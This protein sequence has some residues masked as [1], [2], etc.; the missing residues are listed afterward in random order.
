MYIAV[1][2][3]RG[4]LGFGSTRLRLYSSLPNNALDLRPYQK[5]CIEQCLKALDRGLNKVVVSLATGGGKTVI[6]SHLIDQIKPNSKTGGRKTLVLVHRQELADQAVQKIATINQLYKVEKDQAKSKAS[7]KDDVD[8]VVASVP[9]LLRTPDRLAKY[10]ADDYKAIIVDE[11][12]HA[13]TN[14]FMRVL[15][16]F[17]VSKRTDTSSIALIGFSATLKRRDKIPL[18]RVFDEV[19]FDMGLEEMI[20]NGHLSDFVWSRVATSL[21]LDEVEIVNGDYSLGGLSKHVNKPEVNRMVLRLYLRMRDL[22]KFKSSLFFCVNVQHVQD[23]CDLFNQN[24]IRAEYVTGSTPPQERAEILSAFKS[25]NLPVLVNCGVFTEGTDIPNID[26]LFLVRPTKSQPLLTQM[27]GR[28]LRLNEG[29]QNCHIF[30]FVDSTGISIAAKAEIDGPESQLGPSIMDIQ[31]GLNQTSADP[32]ELDIE[33]IEVITYEGVEK[34][35]NSE[36]QQDDGVPD[37]VKMKKAKYPWVRLKFESWGLKISQNSHLRIDKE[38][39]HNYRLVFVDLRS[40]Q[41]STKSESPDSLQY[42]LAVAMKQTSRSIKY[43]QTNVIKEILPNLEA[44]FEEVESFLDKNTRYKPVLSLLSG[45]ITE[46]QK[47]FLRR[48][49]GSIASKSL[50]RADHTDFEV[51]LDRVLNDLSKSDA[52]NLIFAYSVS[53]KVALQIFM[54][55]EVLKKLKK[56][57]GL[58]D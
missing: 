23:I 29:K 38:G 33:K 49:C 45:N 36:F 28:G 32:R 16:Y 24:G 26:S 3:W 47:A 44:A 39:E 53:G 25:G 1:R 35:L 30:D 55:D 46:K 34:F 40:Y 22:C 43:P 9:T 57:K 19:V 15:D 10:S 21:R 18:N 51:E 11:C 2:C 4:H 48:K 56:P 37:F 27:I 8:V 17:G 12:H 5:D 58:L 54:K 52:G 7:H 50:K 13:V 14:S 41:V 42:H 31:R 6:F 20:S